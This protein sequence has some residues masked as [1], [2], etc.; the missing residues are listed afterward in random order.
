MHVRLRHKIPAVVG[1]AVLVTGAGGAVVFALTGSAD[2]S[3]T[4]TGNR[5]PI[6]DNHPSPTASVTPS[7]AG[8][9]ADAPGGYGSDG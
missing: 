2:G 6:D 5:L 9:G 8:P 7:A 3:G 1:A 4:E